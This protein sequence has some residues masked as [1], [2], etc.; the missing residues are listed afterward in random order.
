M[1]NIWSAH[2][3]YLDW[4]HKCM[5]LCNADLRSCFSLFWSISYFVFNHIG[6][7]AGRVPGGLSQMGSLAAWPQAQVSLPPP[8]CFARMPCAFPA[9]FPEQWELMPTDQLWELV[10][11]LKCKELVQRVELGWVPPVR[12][13]G[14]SSRQGRA[15]N[16]QPQL[17]ERLPDPWH[18]QE[19][20][21]LGEGVQWTTTEGVQSRISDSFALIVLFYN[22]RLKHAFHQAASSAPE[23]G[24]FLSRAFMKSST[25]ENGSAVQ[26]AFHQ[27][28]GSRK[29]SLVAQAQ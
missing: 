13:C 2:T 16:P 20:M 5:R 27:A 17:Q 15:D 21:H 10:E 25:L 26:L 8:H 6:Q 4:L 24:G 3:L 14:P 11:F 18:W 29:S 7:P 1:K 19:M 23:R 28:H 9:P 22:K 12:Q